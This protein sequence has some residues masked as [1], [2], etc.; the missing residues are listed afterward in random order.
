M[1]FVRE[2]YLKKM[3]KIYSFHAYFVETVQL[4]IFS[5]FHLCFR[6]KTPNDIFHKPSSSFFLC[7]RLC[8]S[9]KRNT[10]MVSSFSL[11]FIR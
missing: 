9:S 2:N 3:E 7:L 5:L 8:F 1:G 6:L 4:L 11:L 10:T